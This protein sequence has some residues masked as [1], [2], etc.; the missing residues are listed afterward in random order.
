MDRQSWF[1]KL[2]GA[3]LMLLVAAWQ[4]AVAADPLVGPEWAAANAGKAGV[5]FIDF[6]G[7]AD[8]LRGHIPGAVNSKYGKDGWREERADKVP[9]MLPVDLTK[10]AAMIGRLGIDNN[11]RVV[12][13]PPGMSSSDMGMGTRVYWTF[14]VLGHDNVSILDGGMAGYLA[15]VKE[16]KFPLATG[17]AKADPKTFKANVR[18]DMIVTME[19]MKKA[20]AAGMLL[21]DNRPE[22]YYAGI[23]RHPKATSAGT[24]EGAKN[25]PNAWLTVDGGGR[26]RDKGQLAQLYK[27]ASVPTG[28]EQIN[29]CNS[30]HWASVG[31]FVSS[32]LMGNK[33]VRMYDGSMIEWTMK[34]NPVEQKVKLQ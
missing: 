9:D 18:K 1:A 32:E 29:F 5:V 17:A 23:T 7:P 27:H 8:F 11:T 15:L 16:K 26:F 19:D 24:I 10:L 34:G 33:K 28:G 13:V 25:L 6:G 30:G 2:F 22:D 12:L 3:A 4:Q 20:K 14:K 21:V 31:W